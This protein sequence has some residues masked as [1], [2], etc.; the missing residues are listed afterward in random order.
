[1]AIV[2]VIIDE[3]GDLMGLNTPGSEVFFDPES[4]VTRR[5]SH[6]EPDS[7]VLRVLFH[8]LRR[9]GDK[10]QIA[11]WT[12]HWPCLWRVNTKPVGGPIL[13]KRWYHRQDAID[14]EVVFLNNFFLERGVQ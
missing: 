1:M 9:L 12:R 5:A 4:T 10:N 7:L 2:T 6:V 3:N 14:A 8:L 11:E 13:D